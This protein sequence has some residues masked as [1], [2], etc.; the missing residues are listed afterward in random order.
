MVR[1]LLLLT[2]VGCGRLGFGETAPGDGLTDTVADTPGDTALSCG[3]TFCDDFD[4]TTPLET[5]WD[6]IDNTGNAVLSL[7]DS[8]PVDRFFLLELPSPNLE[9]GFLVKQLPAP[10]ATGSVR[11][12]FDLE[13]SSADASVTEIDLVQLQ[14]DILPPP[15]T[16]FGFFLVRDGAGTGPFNLQETFGGCG[17]NEDTP[18]KD[19]DNLPPRRVEMT[20]TLGAIGT[21]GVRI[22]LDG[23]NFVDKLVSHAVDPSPLTLRLGGGAVRDVMA[24]WKIAYDNLEVDVQ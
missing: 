6:R 4:R 23:E 1:A 3:H 9:G 13:Y 10:T 2:L 21:A 20:I 12:A 5:G 22:D 15:C 16:S 24:E 14:W 8:D 11:I 18:I 19:L 17:G 7:D